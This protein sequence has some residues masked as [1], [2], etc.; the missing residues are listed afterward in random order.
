MPTALRNLSVCALAGKSAI[1]VFWMLS[2]W[3]R[4]VLVALSCQVMQLSSLGKL[5]VWAL[6]YFDRF[7]AQERTSCSSTVM[8]LC[9]AEVNVHAHACAFFHAYSADLLFA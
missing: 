6:C 9:K 1:T 4:F 3:S 2:R 8:A 5:L 7:L